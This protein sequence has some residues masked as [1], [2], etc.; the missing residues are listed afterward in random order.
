MKLGIIR[1]AQTED[2]CP[3]T[4][5]IKVADRKKGAFAGVEEEIT[6]IGV[7]SCGGCPGKK[8]VLRAR[9]MVKRGADT[10]AFASCITKGSPIGMPC[11]FADEMI[12]AVKRDLGDKVKYIE[13]T[14]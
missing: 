14:H 10:I 7:N 11:P 8:A 4:I 9:E 3:A 5:C 1:C 13:Y 2:Y 12:A 6:L